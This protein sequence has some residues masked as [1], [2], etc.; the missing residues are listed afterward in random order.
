M[1]DYGEMP[2]GDIKQEV[3]VSPVQIESTEFDLITTEQIQG[4]RDFVRREMEQA[5][6]F[7][8]THDPQLPDVQQRLNAQAQH[9]MFGLKSLNKKTDRK[10][11]LI[12]AKDQQSTVEGFGIVNYN[13]ELEDPR[14]VS[15][16]FGRAWEAQGKGIATQ[17]L[18]KQIDIVS[19]LGVT[20]YLARVSPESRKVYERLGIPFKVIEER[21]D[22]AFKLLI[23]LTSNEDSQ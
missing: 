8:A 20:Q 2:I 14:K 12:T 21:E 7:A 22:G 9:G 1:I 11:Y 19:S 23:D 16:Y 10:G 15:L 17:I 13:P 3:Y 6:D 4:V 5:N 18:A